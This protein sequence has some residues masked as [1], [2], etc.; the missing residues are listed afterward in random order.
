MIKWWTSKNTGKI[1]SIFF[2]GWFE[3]SYFSPAYLKRIE[4]KIINYEESRL[5]ASVLLMQWF[6][7]FA[8]NEASFRKKIHDELQNCILIWQEN[9]CAKM[10]TYSNE[11][12]KMFVHKSP[13]YGRNCQTVASIVWTLRFHEI[14]FFQKWK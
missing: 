13:F 3:R 2:E 12:K 11:L 4:K 1:I 14:F 10:N 7:V 6:R 9:S 5:C 8:L